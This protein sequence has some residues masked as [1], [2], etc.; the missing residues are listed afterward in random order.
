MHLERNASID[1]LL[2]RHPDITHVAGSSG[3]GALIRANQLL[4][5]PRDANT[6][7]ERADRWIDRRD[8]TDPRVTVFHLKP[9]DNVDVCELAVDLS[10]GSAHKRVNA[11]PNHVVTTQ[12]Q[13]RPGPFDDPVPA[14]AIP[15][16]P[17][18]H[19][20]QNEVTV[21]ILDTGIAQ[22][23]WFTNRKWFA[24]CGPEVIEVPD[25]DSDGDLDSVAGHGTFIAGVV[26]RQAPDAHLVIEKV[27]TGDGIIDE[28]GLFRGLAALR[29]RANKSGKTIDVV[30]LSLGC[31]THDDKPS[32][33]LEHAIRAFDRDTV[34][35]AC[36]GNGG[37]DRPYWPA[38]LKRVI[39]VG[40]L[41]VKGHDRAEFSNYGWWV[42][43]CTMGE[44][45][46]SSFFSY[47][48]HTPHGDEIFN[49]FAHW[50]G[51][52][53]AAPRVAG[54]IAA[55]AADQGVTPAQAAADLLDP[56]DNPSMPDLG[57]LV[58][59]GTPG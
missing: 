41:D 30:S 20:V 46:V 57:V 12:P 7:H 29:S 27:I 18:D 31:Y 24:E 42:D 13:W 4:S 45:V 59:V 5:V 23:P 43:A 19:T 11:G 52:S 40:S 38:A 36:A 9:R 50:S 26:V 34:L 49:G 47:D 3:N 32:P 53:F 44:R 48:D 28:L 54:A 6:V 25:S 58:D 2:A 15:A 22:H 14:E 21:A 37:S 56:H 33:V 1:R 8:D 16:P 39:A 10:A 35:V 55:R 17:A 51:T